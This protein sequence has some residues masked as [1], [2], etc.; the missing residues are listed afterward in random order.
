VTTSAESSR[1]AGVAVAIVMMIA[2]GVGTYWLGIGAIDKSAR[3]RDY[4]LGVRIVE[5]SVKQQGVISRLDRIEKTGSDCALQDAIRDLEKQLREHDQR[6]PPLGR[7]SA[8]QPPWRPAG[9]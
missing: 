8:I 2:G 1:W 6:V 7:R 3:D 4:E 9:G 5:I